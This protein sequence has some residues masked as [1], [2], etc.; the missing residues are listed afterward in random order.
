MVLVAQRILKQEKESIKKN[1]QNKFFRIFLRPPRKDGNKVL[2]LKNTK[3]L[4][5]LK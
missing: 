5:K 3:M 4:M 2:P 1:G